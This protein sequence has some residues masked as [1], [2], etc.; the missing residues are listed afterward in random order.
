[1]TTVIIGTGQ[2]RNAWGASPISTSQRG[3]AP[4]ALRTPGFACLLLCFAAAGVL[5]APPA[6]AIDDVTHPDARV[7]HAPS[8]RPGGLVVEVV[9]GTLPYAVRLVTTRA[10]GAEAEARLRPGEAVV[11]R[12]GGVAPG[13]TIDARL[14]YA[15]G[16]GSGTR[17][18]DELADH[19]Y[20]RPTLEEC[21]AATAPQPS[22]PHVPG[23]APT[24]PGAPSPTPPRPAPSAPSPS[25]TPSPS[26]R[27]STP[28]PSPRPPAP[29]A[30]QP[31]SRTPVPAGG[32]VRFRVEGY[33]PGERVTLA[34]PGRGRVLGTARAAADGSV[35]AEVRIPAG[36]PSG[37]VALYVVG[38]DS[39]AVAAVPLEVAA[40]VSDPAPQEASALPLVVAAGALAATGTGLVS[41]TARRRPGR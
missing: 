26:E 1:M 35:S 25:G 30:V 13:E 19:T 38:G 24:T 7:T 40:A 10:P 34:L 20:T 8:C 6:A 27:P 32:T 21:S 12:T 3:A 14:E 37:P 29:S 22:G 23:P 9:A 39:D 2:G 18:A 41:M 17:F 5:A 11:L 28:P 36:V 15:A 4:R 16:D 33:A 31:Q